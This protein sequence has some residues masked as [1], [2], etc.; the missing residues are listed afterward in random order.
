[1]PKY[2]A[3]STSKPRVVEVEVKNRSTEK[4]E[5]AAAAWKGNKEITDSLFPSKGN[6]HQNYPT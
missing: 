5:Q 2:L 4:I 3:V 6:S 1:M